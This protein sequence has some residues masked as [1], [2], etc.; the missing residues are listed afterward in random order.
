MCG[1]NTDIKTNAINNLLLLVR[2]DYIKAGL[3]IIKV[4]GVDSLKEKKY[5]TENFFTESNPIPGIS[6]QYNPCDKLRRQELEYDEAVKELKLEIEE[7]QGLSSKRII[8]PMLDALKKEL[9]EIQAE[10][11]WEDAI[12]KSIGVTTP[13][14]FSPSQAKVMDM[15][16]KL[17][18]PSINSNL[19]KVEE[20]DPAHLKQYAEFVRQQYLKLVQMHQGLLNREDTHRIVIKGNTYGIEKTLPEMFVDKEV[21]IKICD[22]LVINDFAEKVDEG[23]YRWLMK[24]IVLAEFGDWLRKNKNSL[25]IDKEDFK[26]GKH[27]GRALCDFLM[28]EVNK[29]SHQP[30]QEFEHVRTANSDTLKFKP[31][32]TLLR[33]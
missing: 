16:A 20:V 22:W 18:G 6:M 30:Y 19:L 12:A 27:C 33:I 4:L 17:L 5:L 24:K 11:I 21:L 25:F 3:D 10:V 7:R 13:G 1:S 26:N 14:D 28:F 29:D 15:H 8:K 31:L 32:N 2:K 23:K 9:I